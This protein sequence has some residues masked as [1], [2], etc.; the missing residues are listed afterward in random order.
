MSSRPTNE[1]ISQPDS[2]VQPPSTIS[3]SLQVTELNDMDNATTPETGVTAV[4]SPDEAATDPCPICYDPLEEAWKVNPCGHRFCWRCIS[5]VVLDKITESQRRA[6]RQVRLTQVERIL[7]NNPPAQD[8]EALTEA[9]PDEGRP[10]S[11]DS[12]NLESESE[13]NSEEGSGVETEGGEVENVNPLG[14][15][16]E[17]VISVSED[18][19]GSRSVGPS[20]NT[21]NRLEQALRAGQAVNVTATEQLRLVLDQLT[22]A[23][24]SAGLSAARRTNFPAFIPVVLVDQLV[25]IGASDDW[26]SLASSL[27]RLGDFIAS[28]LHNTGNRDARGLDTA[29][30]LAMQGAGALQGSIEGRSDI[31]AVVT[32]VAEMIQYA[33]RVV[34]LHGGEAPMPPAE[35]VRAREMNELHDRQ[36]SEMIELRRRQDRERNELREEHIRQLLEHEGRTAPPVADEE[37][38]RRSR[39]NAQQPP[40][41]RR[42][43]ERDR[44]LRLREELQIGGWLGQRLADEEEPGRSRPG[45]PWTRARLPHEIIAAIRE[46][47]SQSD[48]RPSS[49]VPANTPSE[50]VLELASGEAGQ[51]VLE[52]LRVPCPMCRTRM[53]NLEKE[54]S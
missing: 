36:S 27:F 33:Q 25:G 5:R 14:E 4:A 26:R 32:P 54:E 8:S 50:I 34:R 30:R 12:V 3:G 16:S 43:I 49:P 1:N 15:P 2:I 52:G 39:L 46:E 19:E 13:S 6:N 11:Q 48:E 31:F 35:E 9:E 51:G 7:Q 40:R 44:W 21:V 29:S 17:L 24:N 45:M 20:E 23:Y 42:E 47:L 41:S 38:S 22:A 53:V 18:A 28:L 10:S 37:Q